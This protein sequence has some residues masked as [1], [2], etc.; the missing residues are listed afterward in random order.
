[1]KVKITRYPNNETRVAVYPERYPK[2]CFEPDSTDELSESQIDENGTSS[3][4]V[5]SLSPPDSVPPGTLDISSKVETVPRER[6][7]ALSRY[8][9]NTI[10]RAGSSFEMAPESERLLLTGTLPGGR[11]E[12]FAAIAE[13]STY[14]SHTLTDWLTRRSPSCKWLYVWEYQK[15]GAL[16][17]HLVVELPKEISAYVK[18]HFK[19]E[20]N[21]ILLSICQLSAVNLYRRTAKYVHSE[22]AT[23]ADVKVC[24][25]DPSRYLS[26]YLTKTQSQGFRKWRFPPKTWYQVSRSLLKSL[27]ERTKTFLSEGLS[28]RQALTFI[29]DAT[30]NLSQAAKSGYR[31]FQGAVLSWSGYAYDEQFS[32]QEWG[33]NMNYNADGMMSTRTMYLFSLKHMTEN[34]NA[35]CWLKSR[36]ITLTENGNAIDKLT[37]EQLLEAIRSAMGATIATWQFCNTKKTSSRFFNSTLL[38]WEAKFDVCPFNESAVLDIV[39]FYEESLT[40]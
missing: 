3:Y 30:H 8:G 7:P 26:K 23:Q 16:H 17:I 13:F 10:L 9:R 29:E 38:W 34:V 18:K 37:E 12:A 22:K 32:I 40:S 36:N 39:T 33:C 28:Y 25:R 35:R 5:Q 14:A 19:D 15:R 1:L 11:R 21:R 6:Q 20:W 2:P 24:D 27:R 31:R 4:P